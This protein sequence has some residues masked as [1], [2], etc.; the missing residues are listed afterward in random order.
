MTLEVEKLTEDIHSMARSSSQRQREQ[1]VLVEEALARLLRHR[2]DWDYLQSCLERTLAQADR[3]RF[4]AARPLDRREALDAALDPPPPPRVAAVIAADGSQILPD[5]HAPHMYSLINVGVIIFGHGL[6][7]APR[8]FTVPLLDFP[9]RDR[10]GDGPF[11]D[12]GAVVNLRRDLAEIETLARAAWEERRHDRPALAL[13]DQRLL[14]WPVAGPNEQEGGRVLDAWQRAMTAVRQTGALL[15]GYIVRPGKASVLTM[16]ATLAIDEPDFKVGRLTER[17]TE[18]GLTDAML[19]ARLLAPGQRSKVFVDVSQHNDAFRGQD[20]ANEVCFFYLHPGG[21]GNQI[22]RVDMP[23]SVA[24]DQAAVDTVH[25]LL[26]SQCRILGDYPYALARA[27]EIA[28]V[29]RRDQEGL[30]AM[31]AAAMQRQGISGEQTP[32][33]SGKD[34]ARAGKSRHRV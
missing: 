29:G 14:Y 27:D 24:A 22:A 20:E 8:Q 31:I 17:R 28:V 2:T 21:P 23:L 1:Q 19:F 11:V 32:K 26:V 5:R 10:P 7:G 30:E 4:R 25:S 12:S 9:G 3:K 33:Q 18:L 34:I 13:L 15:A 16:L 6:P